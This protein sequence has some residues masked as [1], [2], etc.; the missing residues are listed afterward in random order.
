LCLSAWHYGNLAAASE[1]GFIEGIQIPADAY[2]F[3][4]FVAGLAMFSDVRYLVLGGLRG[5]QR[6][7]RH[8]WRMGFAMYIA[9]SSLFTGNPQL[10]PDALREAGLT[11]I[12]EQA[13]ALVT[14]YWFVKI[15]FWP[16]IKRLYRSVRARPIA[17]NP[18]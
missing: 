11:S 10:F 1:T 13:V 8:L 16:G 3:F 18:S 9:A 5:A 6:I 7:A 14:F 2:Y 4:A 12:P 17:G 15:L